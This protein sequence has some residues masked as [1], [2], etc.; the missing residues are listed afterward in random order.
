MLDTVPRK[1]T[2]VQSRTLRILAESA[3]RVLDLRR[4][5]GVA[6]FAKAVDMTSDGVII[7]DTAPDGS[8]R[9]LY[10][11]ES[12]LQFTG[13]S[14]HDVINQPCTFP[15]SAIQSVQQALESAL[16]NA[17][18]TTVEAKFQT[19]SKALLWDRIS[20]VP[21]VDQDSSLKYMVAIHRDI[22]VAKE[23]ERQAQ[24]LHAMQTTLA[25]V[26]HVMRNFMNAAQL[27]STHVSSGKSIDGR[28]QETFQS[29]LDRTRKDLSSLRQ[30]SMFKDR[31]TPLA[32]PFLI[33]NTARTASC[34]ACGALL[35]L[36]QDLLRWA[37]VRQSVSSP[38]CAGDLRLPPPA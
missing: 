29:A 16:Q 37:A 15:A 19:A 23:V 27:Y 11:N 32:L 3:L 9:I 4:N 35:S 14:Y 34:F 7:S 2:E 30:L 26:D 24:Q 33:P 21:Y 17:Q 10:A 18:A 28:M 38:A 5:S 8:I 13:Y 20:F 1:L 22:S 25:T 31:P 36:L 6:L 12:F